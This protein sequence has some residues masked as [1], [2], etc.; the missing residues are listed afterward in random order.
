M[1]LASFLILERRP[2]EIPNTFRN[3]DSEISLLQFA[4]LQKRQ[5]LQQTHAPKRQA[6]KWRAAVL[7][8]HGA[9]GYPPPPA[10]RG[11]GVPD[12]SANSDEFLPICRLQKLF[13]DPASSADPCAGDSVFTHPPHFFIFFADQKLIKNRTSIKPSQNLQNR[14]PGCPKLDFGAIL[15]P[16]HP[17]GAGRV[18]LHG[19]DRKPN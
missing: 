8:P 12:A 15:D 18:K 19:Y 1:I 7:A 5:Q 17:P 2:T 3:L 10:R 4:V 11:Q 9:F 6:S 16:P 13:G 14:I